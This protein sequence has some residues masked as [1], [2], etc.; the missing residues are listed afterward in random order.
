MSLN[1]QLQ[2]LQ[3]IVL[4]IL[5]Q[6]HFHVNVLAVESSNCNAYNSCANLGNN[7]PYPFASESSASSSSCALSPSFLL[8]NCSS[9][10]AYWDAF[11]QSIPDDEITALISNNSRRPPAVMG[12]SYSVNA[13]TYINLT[14]DS[15]LISH[16]NSTY[17][18]T[19]CRTP[20]SLSNISQ[21]IP[22]SIDL[23]SFASSTV[24]FS[25]NNVFLLFNCNKSTPAQLFGS[26]ISL[27]NQTVK[28][29]TALCQS[30]LRQCTGLMAEYYTTQCVQLLLSE[31]QPMQL[32]L[33]QA[34]YTFGCTHFQFF[35]TANDAAITDQWSKAILQLQWADTDCWQCVDSGGS[36]SGTNHTFQG[37]T[38]CKSGSVRQ[39]DGR[40][41]T[42]ESGR[43]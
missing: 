40:I 34:M 26:S 30:Y 9:Q 21:A 28:A 7:I 12:I 13:S 15:D 20:F 19:V 10:Q 3:L 1:N 27:N 37:C 17:N 43:T 22:P 41:C 4:L 8:D 33:G 14:W 35:V 29:N 11:T 32:S 31:Y 24:R 18:T 16:P 39:L 5:V 23:I 38:N 42:Y 36:C 2:V 6:H 25:S